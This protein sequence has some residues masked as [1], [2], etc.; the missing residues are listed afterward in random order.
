MWYSLRL[1]QG[2]VAGDTDACIDVSGTGRIQGLPVYASRPQW[3]AVIRSDFL[4]GE[5]R[6]TSA[7]VITTG[8]LDDRSSCS[9]SSSDGGVGSTTTT[10]TT[11]LVGSVISVCSSDGSGNHLLPQEL[12]SNVAIQSLIC[13]TLRI[14][15]GPDVISRSAIMTDM[16]AISTA[17]P[18][19]H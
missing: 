7:G 14:S 2:G 11:S 8:K 19:G 12:I 9:S 16:L 13:Y 1:A 4:V 3:S 15:G 5:T 18:G 6:G 17:S 10:T